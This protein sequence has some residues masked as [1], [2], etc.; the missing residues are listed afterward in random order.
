MDL[1]FLNNLKKVDKE[2]RQEQNKKFFE[3]LFI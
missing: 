1:Q 3:K 2:L